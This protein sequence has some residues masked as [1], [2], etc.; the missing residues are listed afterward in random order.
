MSQNSARLTAII[1][2]VI[3]HDCNKCRKFVDK[4]MGNYQLLQSLL[5]EM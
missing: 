1:N 2:T 4:Q 3:S 5:F